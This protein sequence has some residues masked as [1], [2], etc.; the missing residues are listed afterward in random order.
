MFRTTPEP[1]LQLLS[2][3]CGLA[4]WHWIRETQQQEDVYR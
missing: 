4:S 1:L 2:A 3:R